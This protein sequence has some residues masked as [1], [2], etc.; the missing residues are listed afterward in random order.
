ML[1]DITDQYLESD[2]K[3]IEDIMVYNARERIIQLILE[4]KANEEILHS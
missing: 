4:E 2:T 1:V 3:V